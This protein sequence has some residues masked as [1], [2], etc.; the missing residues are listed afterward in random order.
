MRAV[1][2]AVALLAGGAAMA[3][4]STVGGLGGLGGMKPPA[5]EALSGNNPK[6]M[7]FR[8]E[9]GQYWQQLHQA[10]RRG[11]IDP[12]KILS[13]FKQRYPND[14]GPSSDQPRPDQLPLR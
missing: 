4:E 2:I 7:W 3:F 9:A 13:L 8:S 1:L 12:G 11:E 10:A 5:Q 6:E 14:M